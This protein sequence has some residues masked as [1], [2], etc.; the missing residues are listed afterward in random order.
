MSEENKTVQLTDE[1]LKKVTGGM[2]LNEDGTY[3][4]Y[5]GECF[6]CGR[7]TYTA[8]ETKLNATLDTDIKFEYY[9]EDKDGQLAEYGDTIIKVEYLL[10]Y[11]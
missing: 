3:N 6:H 5:A 10:H 11:I 2:I 9:I 8:I 1:D 4:I 7:T